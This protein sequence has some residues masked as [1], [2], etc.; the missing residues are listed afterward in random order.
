MAAAV[1]S[2]AAAIEETAVVTEQTS[3]KAVAAVTRGK[4]YVVRLSSSPLISDLFF[5]Q[6]RC[7]RGLQT[8]MT[9]AQTGDTILLCRGDMHN[10]NG[11]RPWKDLSRGRNN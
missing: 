8:W 9:A 4:L 3:R 7:C 11:E 10:S 6:P 5:A 1:P 2:V